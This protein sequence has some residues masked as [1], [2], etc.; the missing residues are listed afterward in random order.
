MPC[1]P[2][3]LTQ[4][5]AR[6]EELA[7]LAPGDPWVKLVKGWAAYSESH[8]D[9]ALAV[10]D[11]IFANTPYDPSATVLKARALFSLHREPDAV[12]L[13]NKQIQAQPSDGGSMVLLAKMYQRENNWSKV[14][15]L[16]RRI[17]ALTPGDQENMLL[18]VEAAFRSGNVELGRNAS[19]RLLQPSADAATLGK[20]LDLWADYWPSPQRIADA[21]RL[22]GEAAGPDQRLAY[23]EFLSRSGDP[24]DAIRL[25]T[26]AA[27]LPVTAETAE[28]NA[29]L[30]NALSRNGNLPAAKGRLDAVLAFDAGNAT[31]L[32]GRA[33]LALRT[34]NAGSA[35]LDAQKL[36]TVLPNSA[37]GRLLLA[38]AFAAAGNKA[39]MER[40][41]WSAFQDIPADEHIFA[42]LQS[43]KKGDPDAIEELNAEFTRQRDSQLNRGLL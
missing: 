34:G 14:A 30:G 38:R 37:D 10:S 5:Q 12:D 25:A 22:A 8:F 21:R 26:P 18:L 19:F 42:A 36:V 20:V 24:A 17:S 32:R 31:A 23:A 35:V 6:A 41:L 39:W 13:L 11:S 2:G 16:A 40:T 1:A 7:I 3:D 43:T 4:A 9:E 28:A 27:T 15:D 33:E 29:V